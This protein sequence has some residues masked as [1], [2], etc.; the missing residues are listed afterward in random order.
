MGQL[1]P[2][3]TA[4]SRHAAATWQLHGGCTVLRPVAVLRP[5]ASEL[6]QS[7]AAAAGA[8]YMQRMP[9]PAG[10]GMPS[11]PCTQEK[12]HRG[13]QL[14]T[15]ARPCPAAAGARVPPCSCWPCCM[16]GHP[17]RTLSY[18]PVS[19]VPSLW[20]VLARHRLTFS[21]TCAREGRNPERG[22]DQPARR[23]RGSA[24]GA[25]PAA[26]YSA[27][28]RRQ[29]C[30]AAAR[31]GGGGGRAARGRLITEPAPAAGRYRC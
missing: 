10:V 8:A 21:V 24:G 31:S 18:L 13:A 25:A 2:S 5:R 1:H 23:S 30:S 19:A 3:G 6:C 28:V 15:P 16:G 20:I 4:A 26:C 29:A 14:Q 22:A 7:A 12:R 9:T 27:A 17:S 11:G